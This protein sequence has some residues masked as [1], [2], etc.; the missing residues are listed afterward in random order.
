MWIGSSLIVA[1]NPEPNV[2]T[3]EGRLAQVSMDKLNGHCPLA[4][5]GGDTLDGTVP[6]I[7]GGK[8]T[9]D[10]GLQEERFAVKRPVLWRLSIAHQVG[11]GENKAPLVALYHTLQPTCMGLRANEDEQRGRRE[12]LFLVRFVIDDRDAF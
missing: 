7:S 2:L 10:A 9:G 3:L 12:R 1:N 8:D 5:A 11:A 4:D 6:H